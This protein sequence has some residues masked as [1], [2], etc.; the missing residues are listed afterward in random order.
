MEAVS[1][2]FSGLDI[3]DEMSEE[4]KKEDEDG[5]EGEDSVKSKDEWKEDDEMVVSI[6]YGLTLNRTSP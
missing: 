4:K 2:K 5:K 6:T 3:Q 1:N